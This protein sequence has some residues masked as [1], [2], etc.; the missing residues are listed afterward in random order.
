MVDYSINSAT[1]SHIESLCYL[2]Q[3]HFA[4]AEPLEVAVGISSRDAFVNCKKWLSESIPQGL[5]FIA[6]DL[7]GN[8]IGL[9]QNSEYFREETDYDIDTS[10]EIHNTLNFLEKHMNLI[11]EK[12]EKE[13][14]LQVI[15]AHKDWRRKGI[16]RALVKKT[17][18][19]H[20]NSEPLQAALGVSLDVSFVRKV[21]A[22]IIPQGLSF[23]AID[24]MD[25]IIGL[26]EI[27]LLIEGI[28]FDVDFGDEI[29][30]IFNF[31]KTQVTLHSEK[32]VKELELRI[33]V[34]HKVYR[35]MGIARALVKRTLVHARENGFQQIRSLC[36]S[37][38]SAKLFLDCGFKSVCNFEYKDLK[39]K[40]ILSVV[41]ADPHTHLNGVV[42]KL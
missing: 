40:G 28:G 4:T 34:V 9:V 12:C 42:I 21:L 1:E 20:Y 2:L 18:Y 8:I 5:S 25:N 19:N 37:A 32:N 17:M 36:T 24:S 16:A 29:S 13:M 15:T 23:I 22:K 27:E 10:S 7:L 41:P 3:N 11:S 33:L 26:A 31:L 39:E 14:E 30:E 38:Y 6:I 35:Q